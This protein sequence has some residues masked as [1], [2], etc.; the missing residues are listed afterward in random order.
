MV[1]GGA[2]PRSRIATVGSAAGGGVADR[3]AANH[4]EHAETMASELVEEAPMGLVMEAT[5]L[6]DAGSRGDGV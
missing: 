4:G 3:G 2:P 1:I 5:A 6:C